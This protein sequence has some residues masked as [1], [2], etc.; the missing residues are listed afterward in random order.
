MT[1]NL[2]S[3]LELSG[4]NWLELWNHT[5]Y[6]VLVP[7]LGLGAYICSLGVK[8]HTKSGEAYQCD[9]RFKDNEIIDIW[10]SHRLRREGTARICKMLAKGAGLAKIIEKL[11]ISGNFPNSKSDLH[12]A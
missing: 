5:T 1:Q 4:F 2:Q 8:D 3:T 6:M 12:L 7:Q 11:H 10:K 9:Q